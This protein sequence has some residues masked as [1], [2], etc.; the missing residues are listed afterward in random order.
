MSDQR[1]RAVERVADRLRTDILSGVLPTGS[2]LREEQLATDLAVSRHTIRTALSVL[3]ADR[4]A[5]TAPYRGVRVTSFDA[6]QVRE[7]GE[8]RV[9]L[10]SEAVRLLSVDRDCLDAALSPVEKAIDELERADRSGQSWVEVEKAHARVH[11]ALVA[12]AGSGRI[13]SS[14]EALMTELSLLLLHL[15]PAF[16]QRD[17][18]N[19]HRHLLLDIRNRGADAVREHIE[20]STDAILR[21]RGSDDS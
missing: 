2:P 8:L 6:A 12:G 21:L 18:A 13:T 7:L 9:A 11:L 14:Y 1:I 15:R 3:V 19:E 20:E 16:E 5:V 10:E 4:L 17:L